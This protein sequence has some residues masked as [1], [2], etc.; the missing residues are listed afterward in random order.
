MLAW[1]SGVTLRI[2]SRRHSGTERDILA[3]HAYLFGLQIATPSSPLVN[4]VHGTHPP[5]SCTMT[6][7]RPCRHHQKGQV[8]APSSFTFY[9]DTGPT[10]RLLETDRLPFALC[11]HTPPV[12]FRLGLAR[13]SASLSLLC[14][15]CRAL[16]TFVHVLLQRGLLNLLVA[17]L[18][19]FFPSFY[20]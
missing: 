3:T 13:C 11:H 4:S 8:E 16:V 17:A 18:L 15:V 7:R 5:A 10:R 20:C 14:V 6:T 19:G 12:R 9:L 1:T 2:L